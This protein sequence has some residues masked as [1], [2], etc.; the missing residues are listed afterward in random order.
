MA[1]LSLAPL[2][3][4]VFVQVLRTPA[5]AVGNEALVAKAQMTGF[6]ADWP[7]FL[8]LIAQAIGVGGIVVFGFVASWLFG[9]EF[10]DR[11]IKDLL[12]LPVPRWIIVL[13]K[14]ICFIVCCLGITTVVFCLG[15]GIAAALGL[16]GWTASLLLNAG[17][18]IYFT[19]LLTIWVTLP[20]FY[21]ASRARGYLP[22]LGFVIFTIVFAQII[23]AL[24]MGA[25]VPWSVGAL[26]SGI[27][28]QSGGEITSV[29]YVIVA[30]TGLFALWATMFFWQFADQTK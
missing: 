25:Y 7:S 8:N 4:A 24:G 30:M 5:S 22:A 29:S 16:P 21:V 10:S 6:A 17:G 23:G 14:T 26:Y 1:A 28:S 11:T 27:G 12:V 20:V 19:A 15:L 18:R 2:F 9:R 3:G 13:A